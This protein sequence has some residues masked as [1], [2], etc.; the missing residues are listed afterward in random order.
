MRLENK[1]SATGF[2]HTAFWREK[3]RERERAV[4]SP[5]HFGSIFT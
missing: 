1:F 5:K 3:E 4:N 2:M